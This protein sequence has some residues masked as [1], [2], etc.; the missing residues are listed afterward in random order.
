M[1]HWLVSFKEF[2]HLHTKF[3]EECCCLSRQTLF[4]DMTLRMLLFT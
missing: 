3:G 4:I 1:P 2:C